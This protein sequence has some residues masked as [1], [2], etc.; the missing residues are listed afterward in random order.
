M[1]ARLHPD[2]LRAL[3]HEIAAVTPLAQPDEWLTPTEYARKFRVSR[4]TVYA[5]WRELGGVKIAGALRLP[6]D[7]PARGQEDDR[8]RQGLPQPPRPDRQRRQLRA[9]ID[10]LP[11]RD[12]SGA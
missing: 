2:D 9:E 3:A 1:T 5:R 12:R 10:L 7:P 8:P 4:S 11:I 6:A